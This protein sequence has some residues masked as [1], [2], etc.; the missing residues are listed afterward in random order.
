MFG[1]DP[2][3]GLE[4][5]I[6]A[7]H[8]QRDGPNELLQKQ[9]KYIWKFL[10]YLFGGFCSILWIGVI[11]FFLCWKTLSSP[12]NITNL[13]LAIVIIFVILLQAG[14]SGFQDWSTSRIM[15]SILNLLPSECIII[16]DGES[17]KIGAKDL[18][19]DD[20]M[21]LSVWNKVPADM[22]LIETSGDVRF[23]RAVLTGESEEVEG[24]LD[25]RGESFLEA[26]NVSLM[27][28][29]VTNLEG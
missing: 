25:A 22:R 24:S 3:R 7:H 21:L 17:V 23:D 15:N 14:F 16:C 28:T 8:L 26:C 2:E 18:V 5:T 13:A 1:I 19:V 10:G 11:V 9:P 29:H 6:A 20:I 4:K 27:G 12:P